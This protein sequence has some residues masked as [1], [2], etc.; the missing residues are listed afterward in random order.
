MLIKED[1]SC[2]RSTQQPES[3]KD[4]ST[5]AV[6]S[7]IAG[8]KIDRV[9]P[10]P[11]F[12]GQYPTPNPLEMVVTLRQENDDPD[13]IATLVESLRYGLGHFSDWVALPAPLF[14]ERVVRDYISEFSS[15]GDDEDEKEDLE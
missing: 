3:V 12:I 10:V 15:I 5:K 7:N 4:E 2:Y 9:V 13:R 14:F 1:Q 11:P 6:L 8:L